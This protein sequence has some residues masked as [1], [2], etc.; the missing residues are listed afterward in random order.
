MSYV[1]VISVKIKS[2]SYVIVISVKIK[3]MSY[4]IVISVKIKIVKIMSYFYE[5]P[6]LSVLLLDCR[7]G[8]TYNNGPSS[9]PNCTYL[10]I[11]LQLS[12]TSCWREFI[13]TRMRSTTFDHNEQFSYGLIRY[14]TNLYAYQKQCFF[15]YNYYCIY[16]INYFKYYTQMK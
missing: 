3:S 16:N 5:L 8:T 9:L 4:I 15:F 13:D 6:L 14:T 1:I 10:L 7:Y 12:P 11:L 2:M